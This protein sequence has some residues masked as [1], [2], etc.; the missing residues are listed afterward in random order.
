MET[1]AARSGEGRESLCGTDENQRDTW[2]FPVFRVG[3]LHAAEHNGE[4]RFLIVQHV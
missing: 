4:M 1:R 3:L 2:H